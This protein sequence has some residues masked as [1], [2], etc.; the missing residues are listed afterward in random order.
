MN[1]IF[2]SWPVASTDYETLYLTQNGLL[3]KT[4]PTGEEVL[5]YQ[6]DVK[7]LQMDSDEGEL[8][9]EYTFSQRTCLLGCSRAILR[10]SCEDSDE[11]D[12]FV[13]VR[14]AD[15]EGNLLQ[16]I[17]IP[18]CDLG[19]TASDVDTVNPLKYPGPTGVLRASHRAIDPKLSSPSW[20]EHDYTSRTPVQR[21]EV[22]TL[23]IGIW[24]TGIVFESGEK[25]V[26]KVSG[27]NMTLAEFPPLRGQLSASNVGIHRLHMGR[28]NQSRLLIPLVAL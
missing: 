27:H 19:V 5:S 26:L 21:G 6:S 10:M 14:K 15:K 20:P 16:N 23:E 24:Q 25:L 8:C 1:H 9:F 17:N 4:V 3:S 22:V 11:M 18:L 13:Q 2:E 12:V 28:L 7:S